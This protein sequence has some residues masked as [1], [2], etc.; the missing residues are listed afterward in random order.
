MRTPHGFRH[1]WQCRQGK[2][3]NE[4]IKSNLNQGL[5][6]NALVSTVQSVAS[7]RYNMKNPQ[8]FTATR[9][10][11]H[12]HT[13]TDTQTQTHWRTNTLPSFQQEHAHTYNMSSSHKLFL[14]FKLLL[15]F[16]YRIKK[17]SY[18]TVSVM[19]TWGPPKKATLFTKKKTSNKQITTFTLS[20]S[21]LN[22]DN[23]DIIQT[24]MMIF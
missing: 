7:N 13:P 24:S 2:E 22:M 3:M 4:S 16:W 14:C 20:C 9:S 1:V 8:H 5:K 6:E 10:F 19:H 12:R 17:C 21:A 23:M 15:F 18:V 11:T